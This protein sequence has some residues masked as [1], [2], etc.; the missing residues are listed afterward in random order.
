[1]Y[2]YEPIVKALIHAKAIFPK[3]LLHTAVMSERL[4]IVQLLIRVGIDLEARDQ[5]MK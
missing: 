1:M 3:D 5:V 2:G 4:S